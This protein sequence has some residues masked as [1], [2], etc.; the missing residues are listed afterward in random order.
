L[1]HVL[2]INHTSWQYNYN[3]YSVPWAHKLVSKSIFP[4]IA[5]HNEMARYLFYL[6]VINEHSNA[7]TFV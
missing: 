7:G 5:N 4:A 6:G 3:I 1:P 2:P